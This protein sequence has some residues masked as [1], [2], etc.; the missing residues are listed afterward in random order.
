[1]QTRTL[2]GT[3]VTTSAL[4]LGCAGLFRLAAREDRAAVLRAALSGGIRHFDSAP[5]YGLGRTETE[6]AP[7]LRPHRHDLTITTKFGIEVSALGRMF[8]RVQGPIRMALASRRSLQRKAL[9]SGAGPTA[10]AAGRLLY[11]AAGY[12]AEGAA[13][14]LHRSLRTLGTDYVDI[15]A[16][17][18]PMGSALTDAPELVAYLDS[19]VRAGTVRCWGIAGTLPPPGSAADRLIA[20]AGIVQQHDDVFESAAS[21]RRDKALITFGCLSKAIPALRAYL[22][23]TPGAG[24]LWG[25]RLGADVQ[26]PGVLAALLLREALRRNDAGVVLFATT[27]P[28]GVLAATSAV[29]DVDRTVEAAHLRAMVDAATSHLYPGRK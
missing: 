4:G 6:L 10:G 26:D 20:H 16:L 19:Q 24:E 21:L 13:R 12:D 3:T 23:D 5:M 27:R 22:A 8:G 1:M 18:D 25:E 7:L 9:E 28:E 17:H 15:F 11:K 14:S 29:A 2:P